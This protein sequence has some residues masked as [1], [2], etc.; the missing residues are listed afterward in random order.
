LKAKHERLEAQCGA[1]QAEAHRLRA[2]EQQLRRDVRVEEQKGAASDELLRAAHVEVRH[3]SGVFRE[4]GAKALR[5]GGG[6]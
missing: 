2:T 4:G 3:Q 6:R 5:S 1:L